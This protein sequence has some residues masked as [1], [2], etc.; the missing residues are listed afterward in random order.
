MSPIE[1]LRKKVNELESEKR[2]IE[3]RIQKGTKIS[4]NESLLRETLQEIQE[5]KEAIKKLN[6][7]YLK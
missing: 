4:W 3:K 2:V 6:M 7:E 1:T 5:H